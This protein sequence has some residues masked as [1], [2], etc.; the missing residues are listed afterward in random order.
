MYPYQPHILCLT[1]YINRSAVLAHE[2]HTIEY[3]TS[4]IRAERD[5]ACSFPS[6]IVPILS[7]LRDYLCIMY[8]YTQCRPVD[9]NYYEYYYFAMLTDR[10]STELFLA[11]NP[12]PHGHWTKKP[13]H[14]DT[15]CHCTAQRKPRRDDNR[16]CMSPCPSLPKRPG[17]FCHLSSCLS[18]FDPPIC[19][20]LGPFDGKSP[21]ASIRVS[22]P[23]AKQRSVGQQSCTVFA[24]LF[25]GHFF[26]FLFPVTAV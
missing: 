4:F 20:R 18:V 16:K 7:D 17:S 3:R 25:A 8:L 11:P 23:R 22:S 10:A 19:H 5:S 9:W 26:L 6:Q 2:K 12:C 13:C 21:S 24:F 14:A 1:R 15:F